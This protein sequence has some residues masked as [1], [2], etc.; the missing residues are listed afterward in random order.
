MT[1]PEPCEWGAEAERRLIAIA[2]CSEATEGVTRLPFTPEHA[3]AN[4]EIRAW[5]EEAG[6]E[7]HLDAA[8]SLVGRKAAPAGAPTLLLGSHQDS[9][10]N[11]GRYDGAM[12]IVLPCLAL[13]K[14]AA[15]G[16]DLPFA[17]EVLAFAD[18][19]GVRFP[20]ALVGSRALAGTVDSAVFAM[21][22][23]HGIRLGEALD[24]FGGDAARVAA[25]VRN[26]AD[27]LGFLEIHIEQGP[28][29]ER[30]DAPVGVVTGICGIERNAVR[31]SGETGHAGTVPMQ[32][33]KDALVAASRFLTT[34]H[35]A[36]TA[37]TDLRATVGNLEL[38]P[39]VVNAIPDQADLTL[40]IRA[41]DDA[42]RSA[43]AEWARDNGTRI[44]ADSG[45]GFEMNRTYAQTAVPCSP[46][47]VDTLTTAATAQTGRPGVQLSSGATH[48]ASAM[49]DLCPMGMV[50]VRCREGV[51]HSPREFASAADMGVA[52]EVLADCLRHLGP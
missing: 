8:G 9:V 5:M 15:E 39:N 17:V 13:R 20:T 18:E 7:V 30:E 10:R 21:T 32:G 11:G 24:E 51:S 16:V 29:L 47:L 25:L 19:E 12:G 46:T 36:A 4:Q 28:V 26:P 40:E 23:R 14:L 6:L 44:A 22:D 3:A 33:R 43:F 52:I 42:E 48:D 37:R 38:H 27:T 49:A 45:L 35:D 41:P 2:A 34:V 31:F 50:F 1:A